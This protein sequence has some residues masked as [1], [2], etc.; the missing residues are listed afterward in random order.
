M[1]ETIRNFNKQFL[2][3]PEIKNQEFLKIRF[4]CCWNGGSALA[5]KLLKQET[6]S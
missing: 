1:D 3:E 6:K 2:Y 4:R 5:P